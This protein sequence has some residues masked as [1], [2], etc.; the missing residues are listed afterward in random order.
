[1]SIRCTQFLPSSSCSFNVTRLYHLL[2][3]LTFRQVFDPS[4]KK[5]KKKKKTFDLDAAMETQTE[6][7][8]DNA[9][10]AE[11]N[12]DMAEKEEDD[13]DLESFGKKKKKKKKTVDFEGEEKNMKFQSEQT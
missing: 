2:I 8:A 1:M 9:E 12:K 7:A 10:I 5:K 11:D 6:N 3:G 13:L 4:L